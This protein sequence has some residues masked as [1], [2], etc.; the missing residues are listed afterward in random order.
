MWA[1]TWTGKIVVNWLTR[2]ISPARAKPSIRRSTIAATVGPSASS[3]REVN[4]AE[5][6]ARVRV[7]SL[8]SIS[9]MVRPMNFP[10]S[11]LAWEEKV[12]PSRSTAA[13]SS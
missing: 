10:T 2:S 8:P 12:S 7:C 4:T 3:P 1:I 11:A 5:M 13:T 9:M 6:R